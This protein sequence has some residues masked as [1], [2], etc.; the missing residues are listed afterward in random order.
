MSDLGRVVS[1]LTTRVDGR[2]ARWAGHRDQRRA[3]FVEAAIAVIE[4]EGPVVSVDRIAAEAG[5]GRQSLYRQFQDRADL[6]RAVAD[7]AADLLIDDLVPHLRPGDDLDVVIR[8]AL[9]AYLSYVQRHL[10]LYR[11]V[12]AHESGADFDTVQRVKA[13]VG[14]RIA[15]LARDLLVAGGADAGAA[16]TLATAVVGLAD[17]VLSRWLED[18]GAL[19]ADEVVRRLAVMVRGAGEAL[20]EARPASSR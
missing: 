19:R 6:D 7:R 8:E 3:Q 12:R 9:A 5:V 4:Q 2:T 16:D 17:A 18:P 11:F 1:D 10:H 20:L 14:A 13:T 15:V